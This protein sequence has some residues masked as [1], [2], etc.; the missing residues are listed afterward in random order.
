MMAASFQAIRSIFTPRKAQL[1]RVVYNTRDLTGR[2]KDAA[3]TS[4][5]AEKPREVALIVLNSGYVNRHVFDRIWKRANYKICADGGANYLYDMS[6]AARERRIPDA[7][8][9]DMDSA[10]EEVLRFYASKDTTIIRD[11]DQNSNDFTKCLKTLSEIQRHRGVTLDVLVAG[12]LGGRLDHEISN[13]S[14]LYGWRCFESITLLSDVSLATI[15]HGPGHFTIIPE[16]SFEG[17]T[18]GLLPL[19]GACSD[20][21]TSGL[22]WNLCGQTLEFGGL[23]SSSNQ[24]VE[25]SVQV[26]IGSTGSLLWTTAIDERSRL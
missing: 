25:S 8:K 3:E 16:L 17:P 23:V 2:E 14:S 11:S 26:S 4:C 7:I 6:S 1:K 9:G 21:R 5:A 22:R 24:I 20:V 18:C 10:R 12:A 13:L 15:L 19:G